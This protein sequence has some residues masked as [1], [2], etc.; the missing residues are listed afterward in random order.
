MQGHAEEGEADGEH[1]G[2]TSQFKR[3]LLSEL[4][5]LRDSLERRA[6]KEAMARKLVIDEFLDRF[7]IMLERGLPILSRSDEQGGKDEEEELN[8]IV[9]ALDRRK[10]TDPGA[11]PEAQNVVDSGDNSKYLSG[12]Q[13]S[14]LEVTKAHAKAHRA[15]SIAGWTRFTYQKLLGQCFKAALGYWRSLREPARHGCMYQ[16]LYSW[17]FQAFISIVI[18]INTSSIVWIINRNMSRED[19]SW[20]EEDFALE[21]FCLSCYTFELILRLIVH[22][23]YLF[24]NEDAGWA[25][26]DLVLLVTGG[27]G[28]VRTVSQIMSNKDPEPSKL[29]RTTA[30]RVM[31]FLRVLKLIRILRV[32]PLFR[33][34][35]LMTSSVVQT[36]GVFCVTMCI[37]LFLIMFVAIVLIQ[38]IG[39]YMESRNWNAAEEFE[40]FV[41]SKF[42][43]TGRAMLTLL[44]LTAGGAGWS[45]T[46]RLIERIGAL[47]S[48]IFT[49][50]MAFHHLL[51]YEYCRRYGASG[52]DDAE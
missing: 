12:I 2:K 22:R 4:G 48:I 10:R 14:S 50:Y 5:I 19:F 11:D 3:L 45:E 16:L 38:G 42:S 34:V 20:E 44:E 31:R 52:F 6:E 41:N 25:W 7:D 47:E 1:A 32:F 43:S 40:A 24:I 51:S 27:V 46:F 35:V 21:T 9:L 49:I 23:G 36:L 18:L 17:A 29:G 26:F 28:W 33:Q 15:I 13:R 39:N 37:M 30:L 8:A